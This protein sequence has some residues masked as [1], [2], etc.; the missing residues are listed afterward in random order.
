MVDHQR[1]QSRRA[2]QRVLAYDVT[3]W[4]HGSAVA[5]EVAAVAAVV[6]GGSDFPSA[7]SVEAVGAH[8]GALRMHAADLLG[9]P[10]VEV[11]VRAGLCTSNSDSR[12]LAAAGGLR[13]C[14]RQVGPKER[15]DLADIAD[16][17]L[18]LRRGR[19][20]PALVMVDDAR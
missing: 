11:A 4:V 20:Q 2:A 18:L 13:A 7:E 15:V 6:F 16:G 3:T 5:K 14:G 1:D 8:L 19:R 17:W 9:T 12:R 10:F